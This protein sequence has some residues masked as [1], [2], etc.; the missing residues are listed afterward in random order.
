MKVLLSWLR[1]F[2]PFP[3]PT[4]PGALDRLDEAFGMIGL[5]VE[6]VV[7]FGTP[8][9]GVIT[10]KVLALKPHPQADRIQ[11]VDVDTGN[12]EPL[13]IC[14]G[15]FNM[16]VGDVVPLASLGTTMPNGMAIE[17]RKLRGEWSNGMLCSSRELGLDDE[18]GGIKLLDSSLPL[19]IDVFDALGIVAD[20]LFDLDVTRNRPDCFGHVGV[21][22]ELAAYLGL[23]FTEPN[24]DIGSVGPSAGVTVR[25]DAP[26]LCGRFTARSI[27][28]VRITQSPAW[29]VERLDRAGMRAINNAVDASNLVMLELNRPSH[30]YDAAKVPGNGFV[31]RAARDGE[32]IDTLDGQTRTLTSLDSVICDAHAVPSGIG[33]IMGGATS[34]VDDTT[35]AL[36]FEQA[37]FPTEVIAAS[38][39]RLGL[40]SEAGYRF[41]R[42][43]DPYDDDL[44]ARRFVEILRETC[45]D[46]ALHDPVATTGA[47][48]PNEPVSVRSS[49]ASLVLGREV[50]A[51][52]IVA[53][54]AP[55]GQHGTV[56]ADGDTVDVVVP[57][58][59]LDLVAEVDLI[60]EIGRRLDF[61]TIDAVVPTS[62]LA[63]GLSI[64]QQIRR[65]LK[66]TLIGLGIDEVVPSPFLSGSDIERIGWKQPVVELANP[67]VAEESVLRP[68]MLAGMCKVIALNASHRRTGVSLFEVGHLVHP[69]DTELPNEFDAVSVALAGRAAPDAVALLDALMNGLGLRRAALTAGEADGLHPTRTATVSVDGVEVGVVGE[70]DPDVVDAFSIAER[71]AWIEL[72]FAPLAAA[73]AEADERRRYEPVRR[74]PSSDLDLAFVV[75]DAISAGS[76]EA[77][78]WSAVPDLVIDVRLFDVFRS[79]AVGVGKR[80]LAY[81]VRLQAADRTLSE[82][83]LASARLSLIDAATGVGAVLRS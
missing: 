8:I 21:A 17:R 26:D 30:A 52:Q 36:L 23:A 22:R 49:R 74:T 12:G 44:G 18:H 76:V 58:R 53:L 67:L 14:C 48:P 80:S 31:I 50:T 60:E 35:T 45:P 41:E 43:C 38:A 6:E 71:V 3:T 39:R 82:A 20:V 57:S 19:G 77:A 10:A 55:L 27:T 15:A 79:D 69:S 7:R 9:P 51:S 25:I 33:G 1:E 29:V 63:G 42:G 5:P 59:R 2:A 47:L 65:R 34:E 13:Q 16:G 4:E 40:R 37:W 64:T 75:D 24:P 11:L 56:R 46:I 70:V 54:L 62:P 81:A 78:L 61:A 68:T 32:Q 73:V 83:D 28:G 66:Q 72:S